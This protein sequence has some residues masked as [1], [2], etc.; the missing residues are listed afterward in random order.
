M[1]TEDSSWV[2][3]ISLG[4]VLAGVVCLAMALFHDKMELAFGFLAFQIVAIVSGIVARRSLAGKAG[5]ILGGSFCVLS[6]LATGFFL[7]DTSS[8]SEDPVAVEASIGR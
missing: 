3:W 2:G 4:A 6:V 5:A 8:H 1:Q 7:S